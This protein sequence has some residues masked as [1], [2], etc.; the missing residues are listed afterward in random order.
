MSEFVIDGRG[1]TCAMLTTKIWKELRM[2][3]GRDA[4]R[5]IADNPG[6]LKDVPAQIRNLGLE[7]V[8]QEIVDAPNGAHDTKE[9]HYYVRRLN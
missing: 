1:L 8:E 2:V 7:V 6:S 5:I 9:Y 4:A 3:Q